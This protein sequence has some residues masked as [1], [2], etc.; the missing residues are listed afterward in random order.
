MRIASATFI[1]AVFSLPAFAQ[2]ASTAPG[3]NAPTV[4]R[5]K[6]GAVTTGGQ[7]ATVPVKG[8]N[9][10]TEAQARERINAA[11]FTGLGR[12]TKDADGIWRGNATRNGQPVQVSLDYTGAVFP[13]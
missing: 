2:Q 8:A 12:L 9:S 5:L 1:L 13:R 4:E 10:F 6:N 3:L 7:V 11:G